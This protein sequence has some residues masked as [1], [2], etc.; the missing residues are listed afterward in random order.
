MKV[1]VTGC[2]G[3]IGSHLAKSLLNKNYEVTGIDCFTDYYPKEIKEN[4]ISE[5]KDKIEFMEADLLKTDLNELVKDKEIIFHEA[6]QPGVLY[7]WDHFDLYLNNNILAT[8]KLLEASK[9]TKPKFIFASSSSVYGDSEIPMKETS[10]LNPISPYGIT[11]VACEKLCYA[12]NKNFSIPSTVLRYFTVYGPRQRPDMAIN[13]F[14]E[15][16]QAGE[17]IQVY[18]DG[19]QTRDFTFV[20]DI[21]DATIE[22]SNLNSEFEVMNIGG[23]ANISVNELIKLMEKELGKEA[24]TENIEVQKGDM[25][26][27]F[28]S[29][30]K[31]KNL[32]KYNPKVPVEDGL[33]KY[34]EWVKK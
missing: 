26:D 7:S 19:E 12:Y 29:I 24:N 30:D 8:Q 14:V 6:A 31:A 17:K 28:A 5:F 1:L 13:K 18:G 2:A 32:L 16:I 27:T 4:N 25:K 3:F 33:K 34:I 21:V 15:K 9:E 10:I 22:A 23:G 11:K 20:Q